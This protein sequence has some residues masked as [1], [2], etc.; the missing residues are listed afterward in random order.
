M[1]AASRVWVRSSC[2]FRPVGDPIHH[3]LCRPDPPSGRR[4]VAMASR[5]RPGP[6]RR[7]PL[8]RRS[9]VRRCAGAP[10]AGDRGASDTTARGSRPSW[11]I[12]TASA[13][14]CM[15]SIPRP[16]DPWSLLGRRRA[17]QAGASGRDRRPRACAAGRR[18]HRPTSRRRPRNRNRPRGRPPRRQP[19]RHLLGDPQPAGESR[20][21]VSGSAPQAENEQRRYRQPRTLPLTSVAR[22]ADDRDQA[23]WGTTSPN[24]Q[25][26]S[27]G[28]NDLSSCIGPGR[29]VPAIWPPS[30]PRSAVGWRRSPCSGTPRSTWCWP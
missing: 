9:S 11:W 3:Q 12:N 14:R 18:G 29:P 30:G 22:F 27:A 17:G 19:S 26:Q 8:T 24:R 23:P 10:C 25:P 7:F 15:I 20:T 21:V 6:C 2:C 16:S 5:P 1:L 4:R 28:P 13:R